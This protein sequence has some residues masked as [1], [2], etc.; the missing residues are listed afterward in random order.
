MMKIFKSM[1]KQKAV[2]KKKEQTESEM[3]ELSDSEDD[4][5]NAEAQRTSYVPTGDAYMADIRNNIA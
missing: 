3:F 1:N 4:D 2:T 5:N